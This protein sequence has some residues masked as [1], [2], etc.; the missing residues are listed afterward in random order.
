MHSGS[1]CLLFDGMLR[2]A[3]VFI[4]RLITRCVRRVL[5]LCVVEGS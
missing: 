4:F 5:A 2:C 1:V 3:G